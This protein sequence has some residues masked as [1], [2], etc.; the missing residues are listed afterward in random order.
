M[1][2]L[3]N[4]LLISLLYSQFLYSNTLENFSENSKFLIAT[5]TFFP[6]IPL[7]I[8]LSFLT[9]DLI[10]LFIDLTSL[11]LLFCVFFFLLINYF[12]ASDSA[13][14]AF[15]SAGVCPKKV[16]VGANSPNLCPTISSDTVIGINFLPL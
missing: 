12:L 7:R 2:Y 14:F 9:L 4:L 8:G 3:K 6:T 5:S 15:L 13:G 1:K 11:S 16:L 10:L